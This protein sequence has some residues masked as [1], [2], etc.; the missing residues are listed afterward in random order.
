MRVYACPYI[1][2]SMD[3]SCPLVN[4]LAIISVRYDLHLVPLYLCLAS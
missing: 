2:P 3:M 4:I 1:W